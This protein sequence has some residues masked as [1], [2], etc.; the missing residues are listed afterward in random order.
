[1]HYLKYAAQRVPLLASTADILGNLWIN[2]TSKQ[3]LV[4]LLNGSSVIFIYFDTLKDTKFL[5]FLA[6]PRP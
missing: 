6:H 3:K 2:S 1:L 4:W 5:D